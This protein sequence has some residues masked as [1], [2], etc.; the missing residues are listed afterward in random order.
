MKSNKLSVTTNTSARIRRNDKSRYLKISLILL[1][2]LGVSAATAESTVSLKKK[3]GQMLIIGFDGKSFDD[4]SPIAQA[5]RKREI[6]GVI[7]FDYNFQTKSFDKNIESPVQVK[8]LISE[9]Q[10]YNA[11]SHRPNDIPLPL[12]VGVDYEGG[13][14]NRLK[15]SNGFPETLSAANFSQLL[16]S[17]ASQ[18]ALSMATTLSQLGFNVDFAPVVDLN[19]N[20]ENPVIG[21]LERSYSSDPTQVTLYAG[22]F[23]AMLQQNKVLCSYK[24][25][26]GHGSSTTDSHKGF[27]DVTETWQPDELQP[28]ANLL[29]QPYACSFVMTA[30][31]VNRQLD[32]SG[33]PATLSKKILTGLLRNQLKFKGIIITD[34]MQMKA[35]SDVYGK[36]DAIIKTINAGADMLIFG[37]QLVETPEDPNTVINIIYKNVKNGKIKAGRI[38]EAYQRIVRT[39]QKL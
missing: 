39:K 26:P 16:P 22:I 3:I 36:E 9:L 10:Y 17:A 28:Y 12:L 27:V 7:L 31:I 37:N 2:A 19:S 25:F 1:L 11:L 21:M 38:E 15:A 14:V 24:H 29:N 33:L 23:S 6:G 32:T 13:K 30:H 20:P 5:I 4:D 35:I 18:A 8:K 34:D